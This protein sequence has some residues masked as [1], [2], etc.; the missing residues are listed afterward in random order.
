[1]E[2]GAPESQK[3]LGRLW[4]RRNWEVVHKFLSSPTSFTC[5][6]LTLNNI[7]QTLKTELWDRPLP[8][9]QTRQWVMYL[10]GQ[11]WAAL[12]TETETDT[13]LNFETVLTLNWHW[14]HTHRSIVGTYVLNPT[15]LIA[16]WN[17]KS[18]LSIEF[19]QDPESHNIILKLSRI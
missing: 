8:P 3:V 7:P 19:N 15:R 4:R 10:L 14:N 13:E 2:N 6:D 18:T 17:K 9:S 5:M 16:Y 1:M 12:Q 11:I